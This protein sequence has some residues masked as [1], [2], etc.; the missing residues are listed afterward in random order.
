MHR[1]KQIYDWLE[2]RLKLEGPIKDTVLHPVPITHYPPR[3]DAICDRDKGGCGERYVWSPLEGKSL[4]DPNTITHGHDDAA[5]R[6]GHA[7]R[8]I[9]REDAAQLGEA[10]RQAAARAAPKGGT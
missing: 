7:P 5:R 8:D 6:N 9:A 10:L 1:L 3:F 2:F 4:S